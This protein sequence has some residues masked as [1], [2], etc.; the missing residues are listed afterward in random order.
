[1][2]IQ[3]RNSTSKKIRLIVSMDKRR[4]KIILD[5]L[6]DFL[7]IIE[8]GDDSFKETFAKKGYVYP[9]LLNKEETDS[10]IEGLSIA[11]EKIEEIKTEEEV[12]DEPNTTN[13]C[14]GDLLA[15]NVLF[16]FFECLL[17]NKTY[18]YEK[19]ILVQIKED[20]SEDSEQTIH[21]NKN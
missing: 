13:T 19:G 3:I 2:K 5:A 16:G 9:I 11:L 12:F 20:A 10:W 1:M 21:L 15:Y 7:V 18:K 17:C 8:L 6:K 4:G 14:C